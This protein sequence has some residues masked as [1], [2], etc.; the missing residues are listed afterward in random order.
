MPNTANSDFIEFNNS[1]EL[2]LLEVDQSAEGASNVEVAV[3]VSVVAVLVEVEGAILAGPFEVERVRWRNILAMATWRL[4]Q[5]WSGWRE[6]QG[7]QAVMRV[8]LALF[9]DR[10][11]RR[12]FYLRALE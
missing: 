1:G 8:R 11:V 2:A 7:R 12:S 4:A 6:F 3:V 9:I 10:G 5:G